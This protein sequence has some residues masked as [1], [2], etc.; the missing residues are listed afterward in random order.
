MIGKLFQIFGPNEERLF[1][2]NL[3]ELTAGTLRLY[4][5]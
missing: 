2:P 3:V 4:M 1:V 5:F